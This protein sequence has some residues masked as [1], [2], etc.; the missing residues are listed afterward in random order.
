MDIAEEEAAEPA[1]DED[2]E[3]VP[4]RS[5]DTDI[6]T[7]AKFIPLRLTYK[8]RKFLRLLEAALTV[9]DYTGMPSGY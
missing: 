3:P 8:E 5:S 2:E 4:E 7:R 1:A 6:I 9:S